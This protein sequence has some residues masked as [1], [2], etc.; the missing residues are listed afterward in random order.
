MLR[1]A[2]SRFS[3]KVLISLVIHSF[4]DVFTVQF[5]EEVCFIH[6]IGDNNT[7]DDR[8]LYAQNQLWLQRKHIM[9]RAV[10]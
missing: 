8:L 6:V 5:T 10:G 3:Q 7:G 2:M 9:G 4:I 1:R